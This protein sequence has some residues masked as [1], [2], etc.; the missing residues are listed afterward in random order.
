MLRGLNRDIVNMI[1]AFNAN[2]PAAE[3]F[4]VAA[5]E[6]SIAPLCQCARALLVSG[7]DIDEAVGNKAWLLA[8]SCC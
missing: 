7:T 4:S 1:A 5:P 2:P 6:P 3:R 8:E